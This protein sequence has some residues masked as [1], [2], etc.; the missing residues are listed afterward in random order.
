MGHIIERIAQERGH[1]VVCRIDIDNQEDFNS[2]AF[3]SSDVAIEF[4]TPATAEGN[5]RRCLEA[6]VPVVSGTTGWGDALEEM[7]RE[8]ERLGGAFMWASN[9]SIGVALFRR[10]NECL[11][12][13]MNSQPQ[14]SARL[15]E[16]HHI[17]KLDHPSG[18]AV[19]LANDLVAASTR[20]DGWQ[21][22][23]KGESVP[24]DILPVEHI[25]RGEVPGIHTIE[26][27]SNVD[28]ITITH[29][30]KSREGFALGAVV[31]AEFLAGK[32]G[33]H[34]FSEVIQFD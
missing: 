10:L 27:D 31:A 21:E 12:R 29:S 23:E 33:Y 6:G 17:H 34:D 22:R 3:K 20:Y 16:T 11:T 14:Y 4:T 9:Y 15:E 24:E 32:K 19:T 5:V 26:W 7:R 8:C 1:D 13:M 25:R 2:D 30:A 18:T 28:T